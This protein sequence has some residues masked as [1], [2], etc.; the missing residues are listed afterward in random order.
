M[1]SALP[2]HVDALVSPE[3]RQGMEPQETASH[4]TS[5]GTTAAGPGPNA[6]LPMADPAAQRDPY[7][8]TAAP[9]RTGDGGDKA[10]SY[11]GRS[12]LHSSFAWIV[13]SCLSPTPKYTARELGPA[14][15]RPT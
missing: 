2:A 12:S 7:S 1:A 6:E 15:T 13:G 10:G 5:E 3:N 9:G 14:R 11:H 8:E 4:T